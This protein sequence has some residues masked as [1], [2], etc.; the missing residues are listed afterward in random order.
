MNCNRITAT[1]LHVVP[2]TPWLLQSQADWGSC[3]E[4][5]LIALFGGPGLD[6]GE[7]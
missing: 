3:V 4:R 5:G 1:P 2:H 7:L 6:G